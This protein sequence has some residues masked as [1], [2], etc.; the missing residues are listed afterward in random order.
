MATAEIGPETSLANFLRGRALTTVPTRLALDII[1]GALVAGAALWAR[2]AGWTVLAS[3]GFC[4]LMY[5]LWA[6]SERRL[7]AESKDMPVLIEFSW[8]VV[9]T[10]AGGLGLVALFAFLVAVLGLTLGTWIS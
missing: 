6:V 10:G 9:R 8:V 2:P 4:F 1:G 7:Q 5:G 3:A